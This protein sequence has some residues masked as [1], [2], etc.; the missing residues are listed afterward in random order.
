MKWR[1]TFS[2]EKVDIDESTKTPWSFEHRPG[3]WIL[4]RRQSPQGGM[5]QVRLAYTEAKGKFGVQIQGFHRYGTL[6]A[7]SEVHGGGATKATLEETLKAEFPGKVKRILVKEGETVEPGQKMILLE[8]MK[9]EF[10]VSA[11]LKIKIK[12]VLVQEG[13]VLQPGAIYFEADPV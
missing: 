6:R 1:L 2:G 10:A 11:P 3:G 8:A 9:M 13:Q 7:E 12:K 5:E 4:A